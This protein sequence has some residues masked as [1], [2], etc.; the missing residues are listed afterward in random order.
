MLLVASITAGIIWA[1]KMYQ[2]RLEREVDQFTGHQLLQLQML[3]QSNF[4]LQFEHKQKTILG[5]YNNHSATSRLDQTMQIHWH[6]GEVKMVNKEKSGIF[7]VL[8]AKENQ[9]KKI[10]CTLYYRPRVFIFGERYR[11]S[12]S[13]VD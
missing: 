3:T 4:R 2:D 7:S 13:L 6:I 5:C 8:L 9:H 11:V 10:H 12:F 1:C